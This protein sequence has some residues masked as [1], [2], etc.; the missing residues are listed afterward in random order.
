MFIC[1][2]DAPESVAF[3]KDMLRERFGVT[4]VRADYIGPVIGS[5]TGA[6]TLALFFFGEKR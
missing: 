5:H 2:A 3:V 4:D 1:H 6:G